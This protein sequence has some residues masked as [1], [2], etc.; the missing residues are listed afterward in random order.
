[1]TDLSNNIERE[2]IEGVL[3]KWRNAITGMKEGTCMPARFTVVEVSVL[4]ALF[5]LCSD[6]SITGGGIDEMSVNL[7]NPFDK[8]WRSLW[9]L[10]PGYP[11][12]N[13]DGTSDSAASVVLPEDGTFE[14]KIAW[15]VSKLQQYKGKVIVHTGAG[16]S[17]SASIPDFRGENGVWTRRDKGLKPPKSIKLE[18]AVPTPTHIAINKLVETGYCEHVVSQNVDGLH[19]RSGL[20]RKYL[21]ELHGNCFLEVCDDCGKKYLRTYNAS[22][23]HGPYFPGAIDRRSESGISHITGRKCDDCSGMLRDSVVHFS[24]S[25]R[26][27]DKALEHCDYDR[28]HLVL[29][30]SL[31]VS[32]ANKMPHMRSGNCCIVSISPTER[33][34]E[35][36][37]KGGVI[38][39]STCDRFMDSVFGQL[40]PGEEDLNSIYLQKT[41]DIESN[42]SQAGR[43]TDKPER[44]SPPNLFQTMGLPPSSVMPPKK[45]RFILNDMGYLL[46]QVLE[47]EGYAAATF[48]DLI[49]KYTVNGKHITEPKLPCQT[50]ISFSSKGKCKK[51]K[52]DIFTLDIYV[53]LVNGAEIHEKIDLGELGSEDGLIRIDTV[54]PF[55]PM[56]KG[57]LSR[58]QDRAAQLRAVN[59]GVRTTDA[60]GHVTYK[61]RNE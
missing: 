9:I 45:V 56:N 40:F 47:P 44:G 13:T 36:V 16:I 50:Q 5:G 52:G 15:V 12:S 38:V 53:K 11:T 59:K 60:N 29:G 43:K 18:L 61:T 3:G 30:T 57:F 58:V 54:I 17:T 28:F 46:I 6:N 35:C 34:Q 49:E 39:N 23:V 20:P 33:D 42:A 24:E 51:Q 4:N 10:E 26:D 22:R 41:R 21:S 32:P 19:L 27:L 25:L 14:T 2:R 48:F 8:R 31:H 37:L 55:V 1:M 7:P